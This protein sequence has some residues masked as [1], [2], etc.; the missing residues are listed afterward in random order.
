MAWNLS[1][2]NGCITF[3]F[4]RFIIALSS[5]Q[6]L[7]QKNLTYYHQQN[8]QSTQLKFKITLKKRLNNAGSLILT[9]EEY[10]AKYV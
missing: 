1:G 6:Q 5:L 3:K 4:N 2:F 9:P 7:L 10:L 8:Y